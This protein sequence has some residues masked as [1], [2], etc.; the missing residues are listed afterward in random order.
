MINPFMDVL[1]IDSKD[2][3]ILFVTFA[4]IAYYVSYYY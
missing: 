2:G 3:L 4:I 1:L